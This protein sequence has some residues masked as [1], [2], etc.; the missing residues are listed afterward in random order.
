MPIANKWGILDHRSICF[1]FKSFRQHNKKKTEQKTLKIPVNGASR[2]YHFA[3]DE[4]TEFDSIKINIFMFS[5]I[6]VEKK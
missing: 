4:S 5:R 6:F 3:F 2:S 1:F